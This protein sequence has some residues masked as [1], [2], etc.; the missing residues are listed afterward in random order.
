MK[1]I[2]LLSFVIT[3]V[4][5]LNSCSKKIEE[6]NLTYTLLNP[7]KPDANAGTW[8]PVLLT[9]PNEFACAAPIATT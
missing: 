6:A 1:K 9:A 7:T 2:I 5:L 3:G 4:V 8:K